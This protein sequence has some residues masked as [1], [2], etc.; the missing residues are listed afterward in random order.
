MQKKSAKVPGAPNPNFMTFRKLN[1]SE[2]NSH[3]Y[4]SDNKD[5][6]YVDPFNHFFHSF[7][8]M[9]VYFLKEFFLREKGSL[10]DDM[11]EFIA[12]K[13]FQQAHER[14]I[15]I[16]KTPI[17]ENFKQLF[18]CKS[19]KEQVKCLKNS[20][21]STNQLACLYFYANNNF[22]YTLSHY[23]NEHRPIGWENLQYPILGFKEDSGDITSVG[24][25]TLTDGQI[26]SAIDQRK[27]IIAKF[28]DNSDSWHCFF[29]TFRSITGKETGETPH[30][31]YL[32]HLW[33]YDRKY[34]FDQLQS[35]NYNLD[36]LH[37]NFTGFD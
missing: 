28:L 17:P 8:E 9:E 4:I 30:I 14:I 2:P 20:Q 34:V 29:F 6:E 37:L 35:R 11:R 13:S 25:T 15:E 22:G 32:S 7:Y 36:S 19:K 10:T 1:S 27:V 3:F 18:H 23:Y 26:K 16:L 31:H 21:I 24:S 33:N 12:K 5:F